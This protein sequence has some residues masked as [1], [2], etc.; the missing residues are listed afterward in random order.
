[1]LTSIFSLPACAPCSFLFYFCAVLCLI[2][3]RNCLLHGTGAEFML[4]ESYRLKGSTAMKYLVF[5]IHRFL[6]QKGVYS[7]A[8]LRRRTGFV[9]QSQGMFE[10]TLS[11][12]EGSLRLCLLWEVQGDLRSLPS[13]LSQWQKRI[14]YSAGSANIAGLEPAQRW[15]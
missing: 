1:M 14:G 9:D 15:L 11:P 4:F 2:L 13:C 3:H 8:S 7:A 12:T 10:R 5:T 6:M